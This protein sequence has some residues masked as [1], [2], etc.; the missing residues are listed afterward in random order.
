MIQRFAGYWTALGQRRVGAFLLAVSLNLAIVPCTMALEVV[1]QGHDCCP[2]K[3]QLEAS[4]CCEIDDVSVDARSGL[5]GPDD[6]PEPDS[7]SSY[8]AAEALNNGFERYA[9]G[10]DPPDPPGTSPPLYK[11]NCVYLK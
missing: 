5:F 4:E 7:A 8:T 1:E 6:Q 9:V 2:P 3:L 11:L 10:V